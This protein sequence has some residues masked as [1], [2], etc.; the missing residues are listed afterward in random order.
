M[1]ADGDK[2]AAPAMDLRALLRGIDPRAGEQQQQQQQQPAAAWL[3]QGQG[4][5]QGRDEGQGYEGVARPP[6]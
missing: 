3:G 2:T 6:Y 1:D 5:G 4:L